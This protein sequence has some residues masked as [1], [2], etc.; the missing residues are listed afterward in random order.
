M[1]MIEDVQELREPI[2]SLTSEQFSLGY[3]LSMLIDR[4]EDYRNKAQNFKYPTWMIGKLEIDNDMTYVRNGYELIMGNH[5]EE[6]DVDT[7]Q[8]MNVLWKKYQC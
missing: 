1:R 7:K 6:M 8:T 4:I 2:E 5:I 3:R